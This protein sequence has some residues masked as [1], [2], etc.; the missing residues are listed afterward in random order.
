MKVFIP[1]NEDDPEGWPASARLVPYRPG[2]SLLSQLPAQSSDSRVQGEFNAD[3]A[4]AYRQVE[5]PAPPP[6]RS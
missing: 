4:P 1:L 5:R 2:L 3:E 6:C